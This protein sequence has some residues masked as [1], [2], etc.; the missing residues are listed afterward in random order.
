MFFLVPKCIIV[1]E[2]QRWMW[3]SQF[4]S[5]VSGVGEQSLHRDIWELTHHF[6]PQHGHSSQ[7]SQTCQ[8]SQA[9]QKEHEA[10]PYM[11]HSDLF[12][13]NGHSVRAEIRNI[14]QLW[15]GELYPVKLRIGIPTHSISLSDP[16]L[17]IL[18]SDS[19]W[20]S[21]GGLYCPHHM[22]VS[23][24]CCYLL[25]PCLF[26]SAF[27][28][29]QKATFFVPFHMVLLRLSMQVI[30]K[31]RRGSSYNRDAS[32]LKNFILME[33]KSSIERHGLCPPQWPTVQDHL[34]PLGSP[35][36]FWVL[37][38]KGAGSCLHTHLPSVEF[39]QQDSS[40]IIWDTTAPA[41]P[42]CSKLFCGR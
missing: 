30:G 36:H 5:G 39:S 28:P 22:L 11:P 17:P 4:L 35:F 16:S 24:V 38:H 37:A 27:T 40:P 42:C 23:W 26:W 1:L 6:C 29:I 13:I 15:R 20:P 12:G 21:F 2:S 7:D 31:R 33:S 19:L 32:L 10:N 34:L 41:P 8:D 14:F 18:L 25:P 9:C 3:P